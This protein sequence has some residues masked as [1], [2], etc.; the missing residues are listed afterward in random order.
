MADLTIIP[1]PNTAL[2]VISNEYGQPPEPLRG[3][4]T[5][6]REAKLAIEAFRRANIIKR[7]VTKKN[8]TKRQ[9][10]AD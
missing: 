5:S 1:K 3:D 6:V 2:Y 8:A 4:Y 7:K 10:K 9:H